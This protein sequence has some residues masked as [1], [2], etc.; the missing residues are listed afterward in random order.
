MTLIPLTVNFS[1]FE[2]E[3]FIKIINNFYKIVQIILILL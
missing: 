1:T 3:S 2:W